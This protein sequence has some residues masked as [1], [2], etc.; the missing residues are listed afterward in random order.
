MEPAANALGMN[1]GMMLAQIINVTVTILMIA[2]PLMFMWYVVRKLGRNNTNPQKMLVQ[3][4]ESDSYFQVNLDDVQK[5]DIVNREQAV[6]HTR[7]D[8]KITIRGQD[9]RKLVRKLKT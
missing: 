7:D 1:N 8:Q 5:I 4:F 9:G 3:Q 6:I 2:V